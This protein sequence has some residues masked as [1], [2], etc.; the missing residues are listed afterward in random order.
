M[1]GD[2]NQEADMRQAL[3]VADERDDLE[4]LVE[5]AI[6]VTDGDM[7]RAVRELILGQQALA[8]ELRAGVSS[9]YL[10]RPGR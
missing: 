10:R 4:D 6:R 8:A 1:I 3:V 9:G 7:R 2:A 5:E